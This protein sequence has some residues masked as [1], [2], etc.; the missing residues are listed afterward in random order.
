MKIINIILTI[1]V[2]LSI[3]CCTRDEEYEYIYKNDPNAVLVNVNISQRTKVNT[4]GS[5][6]EFM[7]GDSFKVI[8]T[9]E[10][11]GVKKSFANYVYEDGWTILGEQYMVW[12]QGTN[13]FYAWMPESASYDEFVLP[14]DQSTVEKLRST[15]WMTAEVIGIEKP[16]D[17]TLNLEFNHKLAKVVVNVVA[18]ESPYTSAT[19]ISSVEFNIPTMQ[20]LPKVVVENSS[21]GILG[22][23][24][25]KYITAVLMPGTYVSGEQ[26]MTLN[27]GSESLV[28]MAPEEGIILSSG[29]E[30]TFNLTLKQNRPQITSIYINDW[31]REDL[32]DMQTL[33]SPISQL[34]KERQVLINLYN[35][36]N[37]DNW[38]YHDN[39]CSDRPVEEWEGV[40][41]N[42]DG[43]VVAL[44]LSQ[45]QLIGSIPESIGLLTELESLRLS[46][47]KLSGS[48]PMSI[49]NLK[50]LNMLYLNNNQLSGSISNDM[51][52]FFYG[53]KYLD[54][55]GNNFDTKKYIYIATSAEG[56]FSENKT[57]YEI[58]FSSLNQNN[59]ISCLIRLDYHNIAEDYLPILGDY[60]SG[61]FIYDSERP[62]DACYLNG[63][64]N[65]VREDDI[66]NI[67]IEAVDLVGNVYVIKYNGEI[68]NKGSIAAQG[69]LFSESLDLDFSK[70]FFKTSVIMR[71]SGTWC[72]YDPVMIVALHNLRSIMSDRIS[73]VNMFIDIISDRMFANHVSESIIFDSN[74]REIPTAYFN[75]YAVVP[76]ND[77]NQLYNTFYCLIEESKDNYPVDIGLSATSSIESDIMNIDVS[78]ASKKGGNYMLTM[79]V[80]EDNLEHKQ[81]DSYGYLL[82]PEHYIHDDVLRGSITDGYL[83]GGDPI[84]LVE[85]EVK[86]VSYTY[87]IPDNI[88][89][90]ENV[91]ILI[92]VSHEG[93]SIVQ[94]VTGVLY[95]GFGYV[96]DNATILSIND[97]VGFRYEVD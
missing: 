95:E 45:N 2:L 3:L 92:Y 30:Y 58:N 43:L 96:I 88:E 20:S 53:V 59:E 78:I 8:N 67:N 93:T 15:D 6:S 42:E 38:L 25:G 39:W 87:T 7:F 91:K 19:V 44:Y 14:V 77:I 82:N 66:F 10:G 89:N 24:N 74:I 11:L 4:E 84:V 36:T 64:C 90:I 9:S 80:L 41:V 50:K 97:S 57:I 72:V 55:S 46:D 94:N 71:A 23:V 63:T 79:F 81:A 52:L 1:I 18:Y 86:K 48:L 76:N 21:S 85:N 17:R 75:G 26:F 83:R 60:Y 16:S 49:G 28:V 32:D 51:I 69:N 33:E 37:G 12:A 22:Y 47:N 68:N 40:Y 35:S 34:E 5:G 27:I 61:V 73:I 62:I 65:I 56:G 70:S 13:D 31:I 54:I 29:N